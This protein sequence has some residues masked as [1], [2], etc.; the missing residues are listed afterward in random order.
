M[1]RMTKQAARARRL[2][3]IED[4]FQKDVGVKQQFHGGGSLI[5]TLRPF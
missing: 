3:L 5:K 4:R 1:P 2:L